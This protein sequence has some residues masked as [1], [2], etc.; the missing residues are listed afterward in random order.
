MKIGVSGSTGFIGSAFVQYL[1]KTEDEPAIV[2][3]RE[4]FPQCDVLVHLAGLAHQG[5]SL[6]EFTRANH[7][8]TV[9]L[10][11]EAVRHGVKRLVFVSS[12]A[13]IAG[14]NSRLLTAQMAPEPLGNYG[15]SKA[16]A[17][18]SLLEIDGI[19]VVVLRPPIVFGPGAKGSFATLM[20]LCSS[21]IPL[22][23]ASVNNQR[24]MLGISNLCSALHF[25]CSS[26]LEGRVFHAQEGSFSLNVII[27][28]CRRAMG[29]SPRL[30]PAPRSF[31]YH[32]LAGLGRRHLASQ[33]FDDLIIDDTALRDAG[34]RP[35][36]TDDM[37]RMAREA[38]L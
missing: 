2:R 36:L 28:R 5:A 29:M 13:V 26:D 27:A 6:S 3:R 14:H 12:I 23:F 11:T 25:L 22:P 31:L 33:L 24:S 4:L 30:F 16:H 15:I 21:G 10:A 20:K 37:E 9:A 8:A 18:R 35:A 17:E 1:R 34:W 19:E 7:D 32:T 38:H